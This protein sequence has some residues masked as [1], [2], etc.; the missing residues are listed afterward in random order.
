[1]LVDAAVVVVENIETAMARAQDHKT[2]PALRG[3][4]IRH[5]VATVAVPMLSGVSIIAIVFLPLLSLQG[6]EGKLFG[7]VALTIVLAL[8]SSVVIAFT[9]VPAL[10]SLLLLAHADEPPWLMRKV[11][12]GFARIQAW[13]TT[14]RRTVFGLAG[15][16]LALAVV[17]YMSVGKTFMPTMDEGDLIVQ[18]Q[19]APSVSLTASLDMD[20]RVQQALLKEVPEIR[21]IVARSGSDDL[22]LDPM[23]LNETDTF[24]V[25]KP[26]DQWRGSK[27]DIAIAIRRVMERFPGVIYGFTQPIEMRVS[28][29]L[30]GTRGD[31]AIKL[32]GSDLA[33]I[34]A[35]AQAI[36]AKVRTIL[37]RQR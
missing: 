21:S 16:A 36:A 6:L 23:G 18:L 37:A 5:A 12:S 28:E 19:K 1:M 30:T 9:V 27:E 25:L 11:A 29:M 13:T 20:Q 26:K 24:L 7:P 15:A 33:A 31:V 35:A 3:A 10:A 17:L 4:V 8:A 14:H 32:F 34:D 2:D 22:G